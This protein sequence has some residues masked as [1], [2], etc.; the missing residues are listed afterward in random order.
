MKLPRFLHRRFA[1]AFIAFLLP[2]M[3]AFW[4]ILGGFFSNLV[5]SNADRARSAVMN[6]AD[7]LAFD[8][9]L[10]LSLLDSYLD[11]TDADTA[12][13][14]GQS[15][16]FIG[17][18][19]TAMKN[20]RSSARWPDLVSELYLLEPSRDGSDISATLLL[21]DEKE[22]APNLPVIEAMYA[23]AFRTG[24]SGSAKDGSADT[25]LTRYATLAGGAAD[26]G[27]KGLIIAVLQDSVL[28]GTIL[29]ALASRYF[30]TDSGFDNYSVGVRDASGEWR[31]GTSPLLGQ[32][33]DFQRPLFRDPY[34]FDLAGFYSTFAPRDASGSTGTF[35][36][37]PALRGGTSR[38]ASRSLRE[39]VEQRYRSEADGP[40][41]IDRYRFHSTNLHGAWMLEISGKR[42]SIAGDALRQS[43]NWSLSS[44]LFLAFLYCGIVLLFIT[45]RR[46]DRLAARERDFVASVTHELKTP[47]AVALS[48]G[49]NLAKGIVPA[50]R[51]AE[52]GATVA[53]EARR[54][55]NSVERLL[56]LAGLE[57]SQSIVRAESISIAGI[58]RDIVA[59]LSALAETRG[60]AFELAIPDDLPPVEASSVLLESAIDGVV[61]NAIKYAGGTIRV[62]AR[63]ERR[64]NRSNVVVTISDKGPG[65]PRPERHKLFEPFYRGSQAIQS[66]VQGTGIG[67]YLAR[68]IARLYGGDARARF[69]ADGGTTIELY[70]RSIP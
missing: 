52:Y 4:Y 19:Q 59:R 35:I 34:R 14:P 33:T 17:K 28:I 27:H 6:Q 51:V 31:F 57:S 11:R 26:D 50:D 10:E 61:N 54:L 68:R 8:L 45:A 53:K 39:Y 67:L 36:S 30:G 38:V 5:M 58:I 69:P 56:I 44:A 62:S 2:S 70:F 24:D 43:R 9:D 40:F 25:L 60:A 21:G 64:R 42:R 20:Y 18:V 15:F 47:I 22:T 49:E 32:E 16:D 13:H 37:I 63:A 48:A 41:M 23:N 29:P 12:L 46:A 7:R 65:V 66:G 55:A 3:V 1:E